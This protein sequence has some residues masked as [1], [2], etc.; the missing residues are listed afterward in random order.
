MSIETSSVYQTIE[1]ILVTIGYFG[2]F[3]KCGVKRYWALIPFAREYHLS[4]C[5]DKEEDGRKYAIID[6][7]LVVILI[8]LRLLDPERNTTLMLL[9]FI[10]AMALAF[11]GYIYKI[12][13]SLGLIKVFEK[14]KWWIVIFILFEYIRRRK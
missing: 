13:I 5:A 12:R 10:P 11:A 2:I 8:W 6:A 9:L 1:Y 4:L 14:S 7:A 3:K